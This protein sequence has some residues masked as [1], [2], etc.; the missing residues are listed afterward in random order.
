M[1]TTTPGLLDGKAILFKRRQGQEFVEYQTDEQFAPEARRLVT[2]AV[3]KVR[4]YRT[5]FPILA[6]V[7]MVLQQ[8]RFKIFPRDYHIAVAYGL[9]GQIR[10]ARIFFDRACIKGPSLDWHVAEN[11]YI[12]QLDAVLDDTVAFRAAVSTF[13]D[14][15][16]QILKLDATRVVE[17][18]RV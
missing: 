8:Q 14:A 1:T 3:D 15:Q 18:P 12:G 11:N 5:L 4:E 7:P 9:L 17:L 10:E 16:R 13:I 6:S 2:I